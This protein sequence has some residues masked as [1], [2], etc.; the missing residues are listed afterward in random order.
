MAP[1]KISI[2]EYMDVVAG[3]QERKKPGHEESRLQ[4]RCVLWFR[5]QYPAIAPL[6]IAVP[7]AARC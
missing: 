5:M 4:Q 2:A 1:D 6:L 3:K 7:N